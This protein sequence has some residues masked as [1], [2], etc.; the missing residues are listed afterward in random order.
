MRNR[1]HIGGEIMESVK[2]TPIAAYIRSSIYLY[3]SS[4]SSFSRYGKLEQRGRRKKNRWNLGIIDQII[5]VLCAI[6]SPCKFL[7][8]EL[9]ASWNG[10]RGT[11]RC[12]RSGTVNFRLN[13]N[14]CSNIK[15]AGRESCLSNSREFAK[16]K[17]SGV[18]SR[19][20]CIF[21]RESPLEES[22]RTKDE[23]INYTVSN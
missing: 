13:G 14:T 4:L 5:I 19:Q 17:R 9:F 22:R 2:L 23:R 10:W 15:A 6:L 12:F 11:W 20:G 1:E 16:A 18:S 8:I 21:S 3:S 7:L